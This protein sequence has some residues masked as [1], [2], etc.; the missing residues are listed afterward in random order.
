MRCLRW[1]ALLKASLQL[2]MTILWPVARWCLCVLPAVIL[3]YVWLIGRRRKSALRVS[4]LALIREA[5][6]HPGWRRHVPPVLLLT[7]VGI[8]ILAMARPSF[9]GNE[10]RVD[11]TVANEA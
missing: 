6:G 11:P 7:A 9:S 5:L 2:G 8:L 1:V 10:I 3:L 4:S